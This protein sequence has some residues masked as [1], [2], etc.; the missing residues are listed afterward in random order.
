MRSSWQLSGP[1]VDVRYGSQAVEAQGNRS[2]LQLAMRHINPDHYLDR[3]NGRVPSREEG[4]AAWD[5]AY[6]ELEEL[7][8]QLG[9]DRALF[10][11]RGLQGAGK[12][13]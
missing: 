7:L 5:A 13:T 1:Q 12:T 9:A 10:V 2:L 8:G 3:S 4:R 11:V 6:R